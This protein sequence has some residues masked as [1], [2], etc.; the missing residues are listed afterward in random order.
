M[1]PNRDAGATDV[2][3]AAPFLLFS[4]I[5][6]AHH[7]LW[8]R[9]KKFLCKTENILIQVLKELLFKNC[10]LFRITH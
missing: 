8:K 10:D 2:S 4:L 5:G 7:S 9:I 3:S 6:G 1:E